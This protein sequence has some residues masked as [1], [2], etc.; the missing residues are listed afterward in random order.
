MNIKLTLENTQLL[1]KYK[2]KTM[3]IGEH[4]MRNNLKSLKNIE[5]GI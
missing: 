2:K 1:K 3:N 5:K 4:N